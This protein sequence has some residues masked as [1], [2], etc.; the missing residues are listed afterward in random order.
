M[1]TKRIMSTAA[2]LFFMATSNLAMSQV[3]TS[4]NAGQGRLTINGGNAGDVVDIVGAGVVGRLMVNAQNFIGVNSIR[5]DLGGG[6]DLLN[7]EEIQIG[8]EFSAKMGGDPGDIVTLDQS[9]FLMS[10]GGPLKL[11]GVADVVIDGD[12]GTSSTEANDV[13]V[14]GDVTISLNG[15]G[16]VNGDGRE[17]EIDDTNVGGKTTINGSNSVDRIRIRDSSFVRAVTINFKGGDDV[18][19]IDGG[20]GDANNFDNLLEV[21]GGNGIDTVFED[22]NF[23]FLAPIFDV[24]TI[25]P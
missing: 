3:T 10:I 1:L 23:F 19:D 4:F 2:I 7:V 14:G 24:E 9:N 18:L 16:D 25:L 15:F 5:V 12:G 11:T 6:A 8:G 21:K 13:N 17:V 20:A 22:F